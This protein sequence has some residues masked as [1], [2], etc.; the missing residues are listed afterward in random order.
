MLKKHK[1]TNFLLEEEESRDKR[2]T[3][4]VGEKFLSKNMGEKQLIC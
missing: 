3:T 1:L 4:T 2:G